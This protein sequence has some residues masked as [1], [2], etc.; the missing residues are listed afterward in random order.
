MIRI[1]KVNKRDI[2][3]IINL[4]NEFD[5]YHKKFDKLLSINTKRKKFNRRF[6][7]NKFKNR[8]VILLAALDRNKIIGYTLGWIEKKQPYDFR[9]GYICDLF[10]TKNYRNKGV[11]K[12]LIKKLINQ[13][14]AEKIRYV[15]L[16]VYSNNKNAIKTFYSIGFRELSRHM[17]NR[18]E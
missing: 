4:R 8:S 13:F 12:I 9:V 18:V 10:I 7:K 5:I 11:G 1:R 17:I 15:G 16:D 3:S 14:K 6:I 2:S